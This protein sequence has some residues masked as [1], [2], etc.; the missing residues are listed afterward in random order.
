MVALIR[1]AVKSADAKTNV[2]SKKAIEGM[3]VTL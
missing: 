1:Q 2:Q 3:V